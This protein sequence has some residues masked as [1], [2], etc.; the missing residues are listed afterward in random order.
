MSLS[1]D[2]EAVLHQG[3]ARTESARL[4]F[5][6]SA[7]YLPWTRQWLFGNCIDQGPIAQGSFEAQ[8]CLRM[9]Q[10]VATEERQIPWTRQ[11][12]VW[13]QDVNW[14]NVWTSLRSSFRLKRGQRA[15]RPTYQVSMTL[16]KRPLNHDDDLTDNYWQSAA[17][18]LHRDDTFR[19]GS[20][21]LV[22][23]VSC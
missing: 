13:L 23:A 17:L 3:E 4:R 8:S 18:E 12:E 19:S 7:K 1:N 10:D 14:G 5:C 2:R 20:L 11:K 6:C 22:L 15:L 16:L 21:L 9:V